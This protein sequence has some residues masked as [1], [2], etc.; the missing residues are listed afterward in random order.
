[1]R[2]RTADIKKQGVHDKSQVWPPD[3]A[4][5]ARWAA[6]S[7][8]FT[9]FVAYHSSHVRRSEATALDPFAH[10]L[11]ALGSLQRIDV[12]AARHG[13]EAL[14]NCA[15]T[16]AQLLATPPPCHRRPVTPVTVLAK[17]AT[18]PEKGSD[19]RGRLE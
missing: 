18:L 8:S 9:R 4:P 1:M 11:D 10:V 14:W 17:A 3:I 19:R 5:G 16:P 13:W 15:P 2:N 6:A 12:C 7:C